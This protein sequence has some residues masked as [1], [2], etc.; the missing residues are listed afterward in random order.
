MRLPLMCRLLLVL[1]RDVAGLCETRHEKR[2]VAC[3][4]LVRWQLGNEGSDVSARCAVDF[5][6]PKGSWRC[7][8]VGRRVEP[9]ASLWPA[10]IKLSIIMIRPEPRGLEFEDVDN[11]R[12]VSCGD[13]CILVAPDCRAL[14]SL[15]WR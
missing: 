4:S 9:F 12:L 1:P 2:L 14:Q 10:D 6:R 8:N 5:L 3:Q 15:S 13:L 11:L 7:S